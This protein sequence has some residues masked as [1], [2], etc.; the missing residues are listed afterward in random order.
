MAGKNITSSGSFDILVANLGP[1]LD[2]QGNPT[3]I[4]SRFRMQTFHTVKGPQVVDSTSGLLTGAQAPA[5]A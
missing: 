4:R 5:T 3:K 2:A 1:S